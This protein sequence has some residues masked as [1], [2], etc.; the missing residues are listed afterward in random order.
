MSNLGKMMQQVQ[1][2]Q[3]RMQKLQEEVAEIEVHG[4]AGGGMVHVTAGGD[5]S[6]RS[7]VID[8]TLW[9]ERDKELTEDLVTAACNA[10]LKAAEEKAQGMQKELVS[11][12]PL[13][14]GFSL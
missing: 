7:V 2:M 9:E 11:G 8:S 12:L 13:P 3:E 1:K 10:A 6:I 5:R 4:E 14:P